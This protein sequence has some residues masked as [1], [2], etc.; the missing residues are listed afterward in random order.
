M[1]GYRCAKTET[2]AV[3]EKSGMRP[4]VPNVGCIETFFSALGSVYCITTVRLKV[5]QNQLFSVD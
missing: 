1:K 3:R 4:D 2:I 5:E